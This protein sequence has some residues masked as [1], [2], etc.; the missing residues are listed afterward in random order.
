MD[1]VASFVTS[2]SHQVVNGVAAFGMLLSLLGAAV[3]WPVL[4]MVGGLMWRTESRRLNHFLNRALI[5]FIV[6]VGITGAAGRVGVTPDF[7]V[8]PSIGETQTVINGLAAATLLLD[9]LAMIL[10]A[11]TWAV[12]S[13]ISNWAIAAGGKRAVLYAVIGAVSTGA[14][15]ALV[16]YVYSVAQVL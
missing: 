1:L 14:S 9:L 8:L 4:A 12:G 15:A 2:S 5:F 13:T 10:G 3:I 6:G 7:S 16:N 11:I